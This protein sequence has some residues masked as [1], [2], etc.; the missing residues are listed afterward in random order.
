MMTVQI[1]THDSQGNPYTPVQLQKQIDMLLRYY[2][3]TTLD[4]VCHK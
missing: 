1:F 2:N 4:C 3:I